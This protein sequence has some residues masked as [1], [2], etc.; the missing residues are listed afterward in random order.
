MIG[1]VTS[2][3]AKQQ[4]QIITSLLDIRTEGDKNKNLEIKLSTKGSKRSI[5]LNPEM[6]N[7]PLISCERVDHLQNHLNNVSN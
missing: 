6:K 4:E 3:P 1:Q 7:P 5:I 2:L